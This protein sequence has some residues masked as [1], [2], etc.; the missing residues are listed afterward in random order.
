MEPHTSD[1]SATQYY[2]INKVMDFVDKAK[3]PEYVS[4]RMLS[5]LGLRLDEFA[6]T[7]DRG[8][9]NYD[10]HSKTKIRVW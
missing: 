9:E 3:V 10:V 1:D 8:Q 2:S 7:Q 6:G 5:E 4:L